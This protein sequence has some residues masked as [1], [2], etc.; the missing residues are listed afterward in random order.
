MLNPAL[1]AA[2]VVKDVLEWL[3]ILKLHTLQDEKKTACVILVQN[4]QLN[5]A[6]FSISTV[7]NWWSACAS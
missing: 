4:Y 3:V 7:M 5:V 6:M 1:N 2:I